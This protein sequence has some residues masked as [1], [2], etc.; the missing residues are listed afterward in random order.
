MCAV[1]NESFHR[2]V[3]FIGGCVAC[4]F[5]PRKQARNESII[6]SFL[7]FHFVSSASSTLHRLTDRAFLAL[8]YVAPLQQRLADARWAL[9]Q[10]Q[11]SSEGIGC[12][13]SSIATDVE[14]LEA[15]VRFLITRLESKCVNAVCAAF[16]LIASRRHFFCCY[17]FS[18]A[19][20][21]RSCSSATALAARTPWRLCARTSHRCRS[22][23]AWC[24]RGPSVTA[25]TTTT[26]VIGCDLLL[27][28]LCLSSL[29]R[30][31]RHRYMMTLPETLELLEIAARMRRD[32]KGG[33][34]LPTMWSTRVPM[35]V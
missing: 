31:D 15:L 9:V 13:T 16:L 28:H 25:S 24:C 29:R 19:R 3:I 18:F 12:G 7:S 5:A 32:G 8:P 11:L 2:H 10:A 22:C 34:L 14:E 27:P 6:H 30:R 33:D 26:I 20:A 4:T 17:M 1:S 23:A 35:T 21:E